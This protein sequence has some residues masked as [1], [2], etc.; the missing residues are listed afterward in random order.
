VRIREVHIGDFKGL[1]VRLDWASAVVLFGANDSG[2][3]NVLE[4][5]VSGLGGDVLV[6]REPDATPYDGALA[7]EQP[8]ASLLV[9]LDGRDLEGHA[10]QEIFLTWLLARVVKVTWLGQGDDDI[11]DEAASD[12]DEALAG[13][14]AECRGL[15]WSSPDPEAVADLVSRLLA[16]ARG[17]VASGLAEPPEARQAGKPAAEEA[18]AS[19]LFLV[20]R[21]TVS[22]LWV[23]SDGSPITLATMS[24]TSF[25]RP[26]AISSMFAALGMRVV[27]VSSS[28]EAFEG[29]HQ[30]LQRL[31]LAVSKEGRIAERLPELLQGAPSTGDDRWL[32]RVGGA[33]SLRPAI[34]EACRE[35]AAEANRLAP[36]FVADAYAVEVEPLYPDQW[37]SFGGHRLALRLRSL[38]TGRE[39]DVGLAASG[40]ARWAFVALAEAIRRLATEYGS[41]DHDED[42]LIGPPDHGHTIYVLDEPE[43]HLHPLAQEQAASWIADLAREGA[44]VLLATHAVPFLRLSLADVEYFRVVR[45]EDWTTQVERIT[46]DVLGVVAESA[47]VLGLPPAALIQLTRAWLVVEGEHDRLILEAFFGRELRGAGVQILPLRGANRAKASFLNLGALAPLGLPFYCL[48]DN[49]RAEAVKSGRLERG[50]MSEEERIAEQLIELRRKGQ[51]ELDV[52]GLPY[53]DIICALPMEAVRQVA[54]EAGAEPTGATWSDLIA[55]HQSQADEARRCGQKGL[56]FKTFVLEALGLPGWSV[57]RLVAEALRRSE[58]PEPASPLSRRVAEIIAAASDHGPR[59]AS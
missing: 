12:D 59:G 15:D 20:A 30:P 16:V 27:S 48:L 25:E 42:D 41:P 45:T 43:A 19:R 52:F 21:E 8:S 34:G 35:V 57:D 31:I 55:Q 10:D 50:R 9:E 40:V 54:R 13:L 53:P 24:F 14:R 49:A 2:K 32:R 29:L 6:R 7:Y 18:V 26:P 23:T 4:G 28:L 38:A 44:G 3:T 22:W 39:F 47:E 1:H 33:V 36:A 17:A 56:P 46:G 37:E 58:G 51:V 11:D 5:F